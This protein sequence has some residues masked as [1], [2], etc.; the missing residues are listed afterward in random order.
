MLG[1]LSRFRIEDLHNVRTINVHIEDNK[2]VLVGENGTGKST[3]A[4]F[5]YFFLTRQWH[6]ILNYEFKRIVAI[7]DSK[8]FIVDREELV[9][10]DTQ[11]S[12]DFLSVL[13]VRWKL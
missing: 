2:L 12:E 1:K 13:C 9:K 6:R 4:N 3:V 7:L 10:I 5:I 8:E 11:V